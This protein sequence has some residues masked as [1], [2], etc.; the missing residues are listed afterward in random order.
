[1]T[2]KRG[3]GLFSIGK[4]SISAACAPNPKH[5]RTMPRASDVVQGPSWVPP[6][7]I[8]AEKLGWGGDWLIAVDIE[9]NDWDKVRGVKGTF[10]QFGHYNLCTKKD[11]EAHVVQI[12]WVFGPGGPQ[13][14]VK[15]R[16][17]RPDG[18]QISQKATDF[19]KIA[20]RTAETEGAALDAV[21]A[22]F[23]ADLFY[24]VDEKQGRLVCHHLEFDMGIIAE[25]RLALTCNAFRP[26]LIG[27]PRHPP[28]TNKLFF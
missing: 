17:V 15:E 7:A 26:T 4:F 28:H 14:T 23:L 10:G 6:P 25:A 18:F 13:C 2:Q 1:M 27:I 16:L 22:E 12:G 24:V 20:H 11:L 9:T 19:H 8:L 5:A 21:L 3:A